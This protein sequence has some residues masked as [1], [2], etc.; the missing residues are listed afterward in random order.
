MAQ[1]CMFQQTCT[2][3][4]SFLSQVNAQAAPTPSSGYVRI[5]YFPNLDSN[6]A[7]ESYC[8]PGNDGQALLGKTNWPNADYTRSVNI[9][10]SYNHT[11]TAIL[12]N[13]TYQGLYYTIQIKST[14]CDDIYGYLPPNSGEITLANPG[15]DRDVS[16]MGD[17]N[18]HELWYF[19]SQLYIGPQFVQP[20]T[21]GANFSSGIEKH[22]TFRISGATGD[23]DNRTVQIGTVQLNGLIKA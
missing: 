20:P 7:I 21:A 10:D 13:T 9:T 3:N 2:V 1:E 23:K 12:F 22:G 5:G 14:T 18:S 11:A 8:N 17:V 4:L 19:C 15:D 6:I 16:C